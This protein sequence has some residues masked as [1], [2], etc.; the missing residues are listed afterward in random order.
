M[1]TVQLR[2]GPADHDRPLTLDDFESAE[3]VPGFK[4]EII[5]GRLYVAPEANLTEHRLEKW[6]ERKLLR[7]S[8]DHPA[9][10]N[11][12]ADKARVFIPLQPGATIPE[13]DLACY[14]GFPDQAGLGEVEWEDVSP[15]LVAEVLV[16]G[17]PEKD[18][19]RNPVLYLDVPSIR[20]YWVLDGRENPGEPSLIQ[21]RRHGKRWVIREFPFGSTFTTKFLP[22]FALVINP[23]K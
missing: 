5:D 10:I 9:V 7:Y 6:L 12:V 23:R 14:R 16:A 2:L 4:Y 1:A 22:G 8:E 19:G 11:F 20:E 15:V 17:K 13:P 21:H 3:Y 18:L